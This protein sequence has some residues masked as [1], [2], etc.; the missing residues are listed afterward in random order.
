MGN[1]MEKKEKFEHENLEQK[2]FKALDHQVRRDILRY[3]GEKKETA[4]TEIMNA[5]KVSDTPT[6]SYHLRSLS[7]F[8][9][10][11]D[12]KYNLTH[13][14]KDAYSLL[15]KTT[16]YTV[17][18]YLIVSLRK[19]ISAV[20]IANAI[21]WAAAIWAVRIFEGRPQQETLSSF[22]VLWFI[23]NMILYFLSKRIQ[24]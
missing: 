3:I 1:I 15:C 2:V 8:I 23:S 14:G 16:T 4:F 24:K 9:E 18:T 22:A 5:T 21:L 7:P 11:K 20:I 10:Q 17:P 12:G 19:E 13:I 6:L